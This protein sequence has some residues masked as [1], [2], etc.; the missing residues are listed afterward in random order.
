MSSIDRLE[1]ALSQRILRSE[2]TKECNE[3]AI[4]KCESKIVKIPHQEKEHKKIEIRIKY[5]IVISVITNQN[6]DM[7]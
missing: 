1:V 7:D 5:M 6:G 2:V 3:E 4:E